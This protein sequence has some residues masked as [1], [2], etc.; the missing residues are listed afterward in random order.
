MAKIS[1][2][3]IKD[4]GFLAPE[5]F[6]SI[7]LNFDELI[8]K[9]I[10]NREPIIKG[11]IGDAFFDSVISPTKDY[12]KRILV[13]DAAAELIQIRINVILGNVTGAGQE[14]DVTHEG[15]Q[16]RVYKTEAE[17]LIALLLDPDFASGALVTSHFE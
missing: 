14:I 10:S 12:V 13:C 15:A 2:Q 1:A 3:D 4:L 16:K 9:V 7:A 6:K 8:E 5:M 11:R 17:D